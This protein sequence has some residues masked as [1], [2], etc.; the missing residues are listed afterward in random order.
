MNSQYYG[1]QQQH[2]PFTPEQQQQQQQQHQW[3]YNQQMQQ[4]QMPFGFAYPPQVCIRKF[5]ESVKSSTTMFFFSFSSSSSSNNQV[6]T[7]LPHPNLTPTKHLHHLLK[8]DLQSHYC[9]TPADTTTIIIINAVDSKI[10]IINVAV[11]RTTIAVKIG[12]K[13]ISEVEIEVVSSIQGRSRVTSIKQENH[14]K[15]RETLDKA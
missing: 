3:M 5:I 12:L 13:E 9:P 4:Q 6:S 1:N 7:I 14:N 10:Q 8:N 11:D 15:I 2:P